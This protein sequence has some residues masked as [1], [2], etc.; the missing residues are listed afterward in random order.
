M[1][2]LMQNRSAREAHMINGFSIDMQQL[3]RTAAIEPAL[4][5]HQILENKL[6]AINFTT[7]SL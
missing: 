4:K 2:E 7:N 3:G 5:H 6:A 1:A